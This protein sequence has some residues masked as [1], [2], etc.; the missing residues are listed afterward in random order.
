VDHALNIFREVNKYLEDTAPWKLAKNEEVEAQDRL[1]EILGNAAEALRIGFTLLHPVMPSKMDE[2]LTA[3]G[4]PFSQSRESLK[5]RP[6]ASFKMS[7]ISPLFPRIEV[8]K[9]EVAAPVSA[10]SDPFAIIDLRVVKILSVENHPEAEALY[11]LKIDA[12][13]AE[14]RTVCAG[15]RKY[16]TPEELMGRTAVLVANL[17]PAKLRGIES[18]GMLLA[19]DAEQ[20]AEGKTVRLSLVN[21]GTAAVGDGVAATG[22]ERAPKAQITIKDFDKVT[23]SAQGG[24]VTYSGKPLSTPNGPITADA[25]D[26]AMVR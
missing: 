21:P 9:P 18:H 20:D 25:P 1:R 10:P 5:W 11:V 14:A 7:P 8:K 12:G 4:I 23:L 13:E 24:I 16:F 26:G 3:L 15:L 22:I 17:K 6:S 19:A 2:A